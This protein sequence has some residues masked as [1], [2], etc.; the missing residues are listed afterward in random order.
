MGFLDR[1]RAPKI[2]TKPL[3]TVEFLD[4][5]LRLAEQNAEVES[6]I[7]EFQ[8]SCTQLRQQAQFG[9][10][11]NPDDVNLEKRYAARAVESL[12]SLGVVIDPILL[13]SL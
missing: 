12:L 3:Q 7:Q 11:M 5:L 9:G 2:E 1:F 4:E 10:R 13:E 6:V 8:T